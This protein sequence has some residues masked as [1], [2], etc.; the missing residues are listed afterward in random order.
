MGTWLAANWFTL[1]QTAGVVGGLFYSATALHLDAKVRRTEVIL[2]LTEAHRDIWER[3][4]EQPALARVLDAEVDLRIAP[5]TPAERRF[6]QLVILHLDTVRIAVKEGA[7]Y[8]SPGMHDDLR[9]FLALPIPRQ[10]AN[11]ALPYQ[12]PDFQQ[13]LHALME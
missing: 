13:Y 5:P 7:Y 2:A 12:A 6:V 9:E 4:I 11:S 10:V 3:L 1:I 8:D